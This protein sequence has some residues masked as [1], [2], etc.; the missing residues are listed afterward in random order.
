MTM[1][2]TA[3]HRWVSMGRGISITVSS[4]AWAHGRTG[5]MAM[6]GVI[7]ASAAVGAEGPSRADTAVDALM[8]AIVDMGPWEY[9]R[10]AV[11]VA[12]IPQR[13]AV[14]LL[15]VRPMPQQRAVAHHTESPMPQHRTAELL[16]AVA[17]RMV[18]ANITNR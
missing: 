14:A 13:R 12:C 7:I 17:D 2:L 18:A 5:A 6:A 1:R 16:M 11:A 15:I 3:A 10:A 9:A 4:W 8:R